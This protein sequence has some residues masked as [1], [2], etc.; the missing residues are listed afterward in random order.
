MLHPNSSLRAFQTRNRALYLL[1]NDL[2]YNPEMMFSRLHRHTTHVIKAVRKGKHAEI[3]YHLCMAFS[4]AFALF[5]RY[6]IDLTK[7]MW[8]RFPRCCPY[9][10]WA[11]CSC[12]ERRRRRHKFLSK[13]RLGAPVSLRSWQRMFQKIYPNALLEATLHLAEEAGEVSEAIQRFVSTNQERWFDNVIE[14]L[15]DVVTNIFGV[16]N[17]LHLDLAAAMAGY[18]SKGCPDCRKDPCK[19]GFVVAGLHA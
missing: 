1:V 13:S 8:K 18:F 17:S 2:H 6:H 4:W 7:E 11:P 3:P 16:A 15:V 19:C 14:E 10:S 9:C 5:N 12:K